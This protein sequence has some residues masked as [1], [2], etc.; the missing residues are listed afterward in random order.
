MGAI[1]FDKL[2]VDGEIRDFN[3]FFRSRRNDS[4][5]FVCQAVPCCCL[6]MMDCFGKY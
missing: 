3:G 5:S 6:V 4:M 2:E 1:R